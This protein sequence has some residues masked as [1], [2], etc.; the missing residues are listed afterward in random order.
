MYSSD[1]LL[2]LLSVLL[3]GQHY[4]PL[5]APTS[6]LRTDSGQKDAV[7][8]DVSTACAPII[9]SWSDIPQGTTVQKTPELIT[10]ALVTLRDFDFS[11]T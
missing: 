2:D 10:L 9:L 7:T 1:R 8:A 5:G 6:I 4:K 3:S 11:G